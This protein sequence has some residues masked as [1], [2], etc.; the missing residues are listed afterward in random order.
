VGALA[1][2]FSSS[3]AG[4]ANASSSGSAAFL[5]GCLPFPG[6]LAG[7]FFSSFFSSSS[8]AGNENPSSSGSGAA[9]FAGDLGSGFFWG[10]LPACFPLGAGFF[11]FFLYRRKRKPF[12]FGGGRFFG[13]FWS[14]GTFGWLFTSSFSR[15]FFFLFLG[16]GGNRNFLF[17]FSGRFLGRLFTFSGTFSGRFFFFLFFFFL[18]RR[19]ERKP[20]LFGF[21]GRFL[22]GGLF[23]FSGTFRGRFFFLPSFLPPPPPGTKTLPLRVR[24]VL[25]EI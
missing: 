23:T 14:L 19:Q 1:G 8:T 12:L 13:R 25:P 20:F 5:G 3:A 7:C 10:G 22:G 9:G 21:G 18:R 2:G 16:Y 24:P 4:N 11:F 17:R 15:R 6:P